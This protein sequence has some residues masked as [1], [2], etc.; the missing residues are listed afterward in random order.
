[1]VNW[2]EWFEIFYS[3]IIFA[4]SLTRINN[5]THTFS[6]GNKNSYHNHTIMLPYML[7]ACRGTFYMGYSDGNDK[8]ED[9]LFQEDTFTSMKSKSGEFASPPTTT[10]IN[11]QFAQDNDYT[12][13]SPR[14]IPQMNTPR[15]YNSFQVTKLM[16]SLQ[17]PSPSISHG[18]STHSSPVSPR[19]LD[20]SP[21]TQ[22]PRNKI[23]L[24]A[25]SRSTSPVVQRSHSPF[26]P[27]QSPLPPVGD[28]NEFDF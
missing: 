4:N 10:K 6:L 19:R 26:T 11:I 18:S 15:S 22:R 2:R 25:R 14:D 17:P 23:L 12:V 21:T 3:L 13:K 16:E 20:V 7:S 5:K 8:V 27:S 24:S 1:L 9:Y 28:S